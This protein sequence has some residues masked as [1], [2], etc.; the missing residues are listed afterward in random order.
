MTKLRVRQD[1]DIL[2]VDQGLVGS[3]SSA[4]ENKIRM[5][6]INRVIE[7]VKKFLDD[8]RDEQ[9][10]PE[11]I[12]SARYPEYPR[13]E[14]GEIIA[15]IIIPTIVITVR[16]GPSSEVGIGRKI[17]D[18]LDGWA[19]GFRQKVFIEFDCH[20][21]DEMVADQLAGWAAEEFQIHKVG[22]LQQAGF[23]N[24][25]QLYSRPAH[26]FDF[27]AP[28]DFTER[29]FPLRLFRHMLYL[30]TEFEVVWITKYTSEAIITN[31]VFNNQDD[32]Y[33]DM[34]MGM[35]L[36]YLLAEEIYYGLHGVIS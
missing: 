18:T 14:K 12:V 25:E 9:G 24:F 4:T 15:E 31:I 7:Q 29:W 34:N 2:V 33:I 35:S 19:Y 10:I 30:T 11:L 8:R 26:G 5:S 1:G 32:I 22:L 16:V 21:G 36:E 13:G 27:S 3:I 23:I 20:G 6:F 28:W 17:R